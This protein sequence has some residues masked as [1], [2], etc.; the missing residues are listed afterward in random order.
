MEQ[1]EILVKSTLDGSLQPSLYYPASTK[2]RP[3]LVGLHTW[4]NTRTNQIRNLVPVA[5]RNDFN[6]LLPEFRGPNLTTNPKCTEA[7]GSQLAM[8]DIKD[9]ID[10]LI[11]KEE[12]DKDNIFIVGAS[13][14][15]HMA[16]MMAGFIPEYF[17][18]IAACVP[19]T[20]LKKWEEY[21]DC[22]R[23][24]ILACCSNSEEEMAKRSPYTY[25]ENIAKSNIKILHGK[26]DNVVPYRQSLDFYLECLEKYPDARVFYEIFDGGHEMN[27]K[28]IEL[29]IL[30]QY[31]EKQNVEVTG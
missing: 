15:G 4:S 16:M 25:M 10:Y 30:S 18:A 22:Y 5:E 14:G 21:S 1:T 24:H 11:E 20:H 12:I 27:L 2:G 31:K 7:C 29:W 9:A 13:G 6:L 28:S 17:R 26:T 8:Q 23:P 3:L 19:I